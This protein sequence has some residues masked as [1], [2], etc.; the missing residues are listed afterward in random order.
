MVNIVG[1]DL[2]SDGQPSRFQGKRILEYYD[3][4]GYS[5][6]ELPGYVL[7]FALAFFLLTWA[8]LQLK[9]LARQVSQGRGIPTDS[10]I[11]DC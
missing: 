10:L 3:F 8:A 5:K 1:V 9:R 6:W 7:L 4:D 2:G 11:A